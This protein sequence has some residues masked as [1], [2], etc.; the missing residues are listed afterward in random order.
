MAT[1]FWQEFIFATT[2]LLL[3]SCI[4]NQEILRP[5]PSRVPMTVY[6][7]SDR[8]LG[9]GRS[10]C[11][12][13][14]SCYFYGVFYNQPCSQ[15]DIENW[16]LFCS[17]SDQNL[18]SPFRLPSSLKYNQNM[19]TSYH[20]PFFSPL[21]TPFPVLPGICSRASSKVMAPIHPN[22]SALK[23]SG[24]WVSAKLAHLKV[25]G[26]FST[27]VSSSLICFEYETFSKGS[28][29]GTLGPGRQ[30]HYL[31]RW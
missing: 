15:R 23:S 1:L 21:L 31:G 5:L 4:R 28:C 25:Q 6:C 10:P 11:P 13:A 17:S 2:F 12:S 30:W 9:P 8:D 22:L 24:S 18:L 26:L 29:V 19:A 14:F 3:C 27:W 7:C 20:P 16:N